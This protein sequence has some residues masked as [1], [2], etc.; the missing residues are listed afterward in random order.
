MTKVL[1]FTEMSF[2]GSGYYYLMSPMLQKMSEMGYDIKVIGLSYEGA[3]Y[4]Y[5]FSIVGAQTV[6]DGV[7]MATNIIKLWQPDIFIC[8]LDIPLQISIH[9]AIKELKVPYIAVTPLENPPLVQS[10]TAS[11]MMMDYVFFISELGKQ[12]ALKAGLTKTDHLLVGVDS[13]SFRVPTSEER[14]KLREDFGYTDE[15][16]ILTVADNQERKNIWAEF[17]II[18][19]LKQAGK[20][21]KFVLVTREHSPVGYKLRDMAMDYDLNKEL[22]IIER[23]ISQQD[24]WKL[25]ASSDVYLSTSKAEGLGIPILEAMAS[26][27][28]VVATDTGAITEL[29]E[30]GRGLL[31]APA[32]K[33]IDVWGNSWRHL[34]DTNMAAHLLMLVDPTI[35]GTSTARKY[36][37]SRTFDIP[38]K[39][40]D[41]KIKEILNVTEN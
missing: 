19:K 24:L 18:S 38:A 36:V 17:E 2:Q 14:A 39:Q 32:Y 33:F 5:G 1:V 34:I 25:Y 12:A 15:F 6:S 10:W 35:R 7:A 28:P 3:E 20:K 4:S 16:V 37:E 26:G 40:M 21:V 9:N 27:L 29:L 8:G 23:G 13:E 30:D 11:L 31:V 41:K 22:I